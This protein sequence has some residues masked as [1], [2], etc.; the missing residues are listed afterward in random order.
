MSLLIFVGRWSWVAVVA[1][2]L[3]IGAYWF[4]TINAIE[5]SARLVAE[6]GAL[7]EHQDALLQAQL[8]AALTGE[9]GVASEA[10]AEILKDAEAAAAT[11]IAGVDPD[12]EAARDR[13]IAGAIDAAVR[14]LHALATIGGGQPDQSVRALRLNPAFGDDRSAATPPAANDES[15][16]DLDLAMIGLRY[17]AVSSSATANLDDATA[18]LADDGLE[19]AGRLQPSGRFG[20]GFLLIGGLASTSGLAWSGHRARTL[21]RNVERSN[22][23]EA[24]K[25]E[26]IALASHE[27]RTPLVGSMDSQ[28]CYWV[29]SSCLSTPGRGRSTSMLRPADLPESSKTCSV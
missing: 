20:I 26:F 24:L 7:R 2:S 4:R 8:A 9:R 21:S 25:S 22:E 11:L 3:L 16:D 15:M 18:A 1:V 10:S 27:L 29:R 6:V 14:D 23:V 13:R 12:R 19:A 17:A 28:S 5:D